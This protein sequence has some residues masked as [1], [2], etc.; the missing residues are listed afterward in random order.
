MKCL[1]LKHSRSK[2]KILELDDTRARMKPY[3]VKSSAATHGAAPKSLPNP[4][5]CHWAIT[6]Y[7]SSRKTQASLHTFKSTSKA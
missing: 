6:I 1:S 4:R 3:G 5:D 2:T 7:H